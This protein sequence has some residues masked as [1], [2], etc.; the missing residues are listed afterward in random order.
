MPTR[1]SPPRATSSTASA[2]VRWQLRLTACSP[3]PWLLDGKE[4]VDGSSPSEGFEFCLLSRYFRCLDGRRLRV[5]SASG[6]S[7]GRGPQRGAR[8]GSAI[9]SLCRRARERVDE[10]DDEARADEVASASL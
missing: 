3:R 4:G 5:T 1:S 9:G 7:N 2:P 10:P 8:T 6:T